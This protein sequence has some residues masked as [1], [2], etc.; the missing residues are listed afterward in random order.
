MLPRSLLTTPGG[1]RR[2]AAIG[3]AVSLVLAGAWA[4]TS[5]PAAP[6]TEASRSAPMGALTATSGS[7]SDFADLVR[8][9]SNRCDLQPVELMTYPDTSRLQGSCCYRMNAAR[10][11]AQL[12]GLR[13]YARVPAIPTNPYDIPARLAKQLLR[14]QR[15]IP[16][17]ASQRATYS[18]TMSMTDEKGPCCCHCWRWDAFQGL[19][20]HLIAERGWNAR[21][22][23]AVIDLEDGCGGPADAPQPMHS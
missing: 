2:F 1:R 17:S 15:S 7:R 11:H 19:S 3:I 10:Y 12:R 21:Q 23:A 14:Y 13:R 16:P 6:R 22:V 8:Q 18:R 20:N 4:L 5:Q 9:T